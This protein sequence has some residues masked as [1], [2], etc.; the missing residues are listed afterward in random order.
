MAN[1]LY[2]LG[3]RKLSNK[4]LGVLVFIA[5]IAL[6]HLAIFGAAG[7]LSGGWTFNPEQ[8]RIGITRTI[9]PFFAGLLLSRVAKPTR[10][11]HAFLLCSVLVA[12]LLFMPRIGGA[13]HVWMNGVYESICIILIFPLIVYLGASGVIH[14]ERESRICK[15]LG[16]IS[17]PLYMVH[18]SLL[19]FYVAWVSNHKGI[20]ISDAWPYA[21][22]SLV[23]SIALAYVS[24]KWYDEPVRKWLRQKLG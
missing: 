16:D 11:K 19:Y 15:F 13:E 6:A 17:Y 14:T 1:I 8:L 3:L 7:D 20:T 21:L 12:V 10:I 9:Y 23:G 18:Y 4:A 2:A 24:L 5:A 22:L